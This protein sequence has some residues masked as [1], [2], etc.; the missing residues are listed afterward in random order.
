MNDRV[1]NYFNTIADKLAIDH[2]LTGN[3]KN[4][5]DIGYNREKLVQTFLK[6]HIPKRLFPVLGGHIFGFEQPESKQI[7]VIILN[8]C[9][10]NFEEHEKLFTPI[11]N[12]AAAFSVKSNL[13]SANLIASLENIASIPQIDSDIIKFKFLP[14]SVF[15]DFVKYNPCFF[16]FAYEGVSL[17][18]SLDTID[19]FYKKNT[20]IPLNRRP[21]GIIVNKK[22]YI[23]CTPDQSLRMDKT[24]VQPYDFNGMKLMQ[25]FQGFPF[26]HIFNCINS[27][28]DWLSKMTISYL[29]YFNTFTSKYYESLPD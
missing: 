11:E 19:N 16:I 25:E 23:R 4:S 12:V 22:Y 15:S 27:Y 6:N 10:L 17:E 9:G 26:F 8:D 14:E 1:F 5:S 13:D 24:I 21:C 28:V 20:N 29:K 7:D 18:T 2:Q 3:G